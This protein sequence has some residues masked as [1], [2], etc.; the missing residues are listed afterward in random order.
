MFGQKLRRS[1][2]RLFLQVIRNNRL[3]GLKGEA[4]GRFD[5]RSKRYTVGCPSGPA[6]ARAYNQAILIGKIFQNLGVGASEA[7]GTELDGLL[8]N[9]PEITGL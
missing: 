5:I 9:M 6:N 7:A 4:G 8:K 2:A 3:A 1:E